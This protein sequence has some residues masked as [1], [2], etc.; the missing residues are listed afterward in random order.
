MMTG[1]LDEVFQRTDAGGARVF[2]ADALGSTLALTDSA[3]GIQTQYTYEPFGSTT[4][5]GPV[6]GNPTQYTGRDNDGTN[7]YFYR[8]RYF[9]PSTQ[10]FISE[11]PLGA[12][13]AD[14]NLFAYARNAP[15]LYT[16]PTGMIVMRVRPGMCPSCDKL[17]GRRKT[18]AWERFWCGIELGSALPTPLAL[19][20]PAENAG[21]RALFGREARGA[22]ASIDRLMAGER[23]VLPEGVTPDTLRRYLELADRIVKAGLD[24]V[25]T[26]AARR[27]AI[28]LLLNQL[29]LK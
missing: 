25:G 18:T 20:G 28:E 15:T 8:A 13:G 10:R 3:G 29:G 14:I 11:D 27:Q 22:R 26:Q 2:L 5:S 24:T 7:A 12:A 23:V 6:G 1:M 19:F 4:A 17:Q 16:D 9:S 21:L